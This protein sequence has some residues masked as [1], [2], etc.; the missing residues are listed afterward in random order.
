MA[1][2]IIAPGYGAVWQGTF[3]QRFD[4]ELV[5]IVEDIRSLAV[6]RRGTYADR[7]EVIDRL[8]ARFNELDMVWDPVDLSIVELPAGKRFKIT[9]YDGA[10][11]VITEDELTHTAP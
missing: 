2:F 3:E 5:R 4:P 9:S 1:K 11:Y 7:L 10:E 8:K 6:N